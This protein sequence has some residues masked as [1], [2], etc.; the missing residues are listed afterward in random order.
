MCRM[1]ITRIKKGFYCYKVGYIVYIY[2]INKNVNKIILQNLWL[3]SISTE[4]K[5]YSALLAW[6]HPAAFLFLVAVAV[7]L[8]KEELYEN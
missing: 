1:K 8:K 2:T 6:W 4:I 7:V 3:L 5:I